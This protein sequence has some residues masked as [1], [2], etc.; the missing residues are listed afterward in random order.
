VDDF[1]ARAVDYGGQMFAVGKALHAV[2][3]PV[4]PNL[5]FSSASKSLT[6]HHNAVENKELI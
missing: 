4:S 1:A 6:L 5:P 3:I 2:F